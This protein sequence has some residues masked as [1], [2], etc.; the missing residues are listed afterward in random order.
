QLVSGQK[1]DSYGALGRERLLSLSFRQEQ[2]RVA[3]FQET[4]TLADV[5]LTALGTTLDRMAAIG[6][7]AKMALDPN[8]FL[9]Q[10]D[11][12]TADQKAARNYL[13]EL[14]A[15][16]N[17]EVGG[18]YVFAGKAVDQQPVDTLDRILEGD[19]ARA[20]LRQVTAERL[21]ADRGADGLGRLSLPP[22]AGTTVTLAQEADG[23][24]F[25]FRLE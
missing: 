16:L 6:R 14:A 12:T 17:S 22:V 7:D 25:G 10:A 19:G 23:L 2:A 13:E 1:A 24:P 9:V 3:A 15:L 18:R 5:R 20:G 4:I 21:E 11:G 8:R